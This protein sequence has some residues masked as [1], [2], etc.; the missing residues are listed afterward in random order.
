[1]VALRRSE[2]PLCPGCRALG[3]AEE[4]L[5]PVVAKLP[6][7]VPQ[8]E[9]VVEEIVHRGPSRRVVSGYVHVAPAER[10]EATHRALSPGGRWRAAS[11]TAWR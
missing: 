3:L 2:P 6:C 10:H 1:M 4:L 5:Q 7:E 8:P 11:S 9:H